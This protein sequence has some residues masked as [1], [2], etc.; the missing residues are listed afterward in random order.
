MRQREK[1]FDIQR[2]TRVASGGQFTSNQLSND[3]S[4]NTILLLTLLS[5]N[6]ADMV[7]TV[8]MVLF[9]LLACF[10]VF[11]GPLPNRLVWI[12]LICHFPP[13]SSSVNMGLE[14]GEVVHFYYSYGSYIY[15]D[16]A[17]QKTTAPLLMEAAALLASPHS[18][19]SGHPLKMDSG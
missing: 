6:P 10:F 2:N 19:H 11:F 13:S 14:C 5:V 3:H 18:C 16:T 17:M 1:N 9:T 4:V 7:H 15:L 8:D 12:S